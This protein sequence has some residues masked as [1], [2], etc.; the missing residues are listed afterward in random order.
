MGGNQRE[1]VEVGGPLSR[2]KVTSTVN[3]AKKKRASQY[4]MTNVSVINSRWWVAISVINI[5][6]A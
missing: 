2:A 5:A 4:R 1:W 6:Y 3:Y